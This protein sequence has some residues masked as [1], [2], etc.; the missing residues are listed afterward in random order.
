M[1]ERPRFKLRGRVRD[2][3]LQSC[4]LR[5]RA[6]AALASRELLDLLVRDRLL[7]HGRGR[8]ELR[9]IHLCADLGLDLLRD[10]RVFLEEIARIVLA[11]AEPVAALKA[12]SADPTCRA[13]VALSDGRTVR[14]VD[15]QWEFLDWAR[16]YLAERDV[17]PVTAEV[18]GWVQTQPSS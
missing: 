8:A 12:I 17:D 15:L 4:R 14:A 9:G 10:G 16:K 7:C 18:R 3:R 2:V 6:A 13:T 1:P 11:L 5:G